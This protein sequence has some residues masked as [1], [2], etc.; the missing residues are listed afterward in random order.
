[1][2]PEMAAQNALVNL[3]ALRFYLSTGFVKMHT[4]RRSTCIEIE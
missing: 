3:F 1:M 2:A 4:L